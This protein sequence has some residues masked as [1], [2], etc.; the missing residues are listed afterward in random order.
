LFQMAEKTPKKDAAAVALGK[1]GGTAT[2][3]NRTKAERSEA[4]RKAVLARW[5]K[6][7]K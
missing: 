1:K 2:A 7:A 4:A 6:K 3:K 5:G